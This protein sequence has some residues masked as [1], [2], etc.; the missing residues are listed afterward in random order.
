MIFIAHILLFGAILNPINWYN[1]PSLHQIEIECK[2]YTYL[3][4]LI[5]RIIKCLKFNLLK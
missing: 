4:L 2:I 5:R 1:N 3:L